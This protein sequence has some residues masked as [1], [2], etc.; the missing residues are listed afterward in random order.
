MA[1]KESKFDINTEL[2]SKTVNQFAN[3]IR[4]ERNT[5]NSFLSIYA[6]KSIIDKL[7]NINNQIIYGRRGTGKSH[8]ML[9]LQETLL[10]ENMKKT[11]K[12]LPV[13]YQTSTWI[14]GRMAASGNTYCPYPLAII[15]KASS[16]RDTSQRI[17]FMIENRYMRK[18][19]LFLLA[20]QVLIYGCAVYH[21]QSTDIPLINHK[22]ELRIDA[23]A[24]IVPS[25][26]STIS[27]GL[28]NKIAVQAF[29]SA[30]VEERY[31]FQFSP[32]FY[33]TLQNKKVIELYGG[34]GFGHANTVK[35]P[36]A[37]MP[38]ATKQSLYGNYQLYFAQFNWGKNT[39]ES[40]RLDWAIGLK[41][42]FFHSDLT[43][44]NYYRIYPE[45][46]PFSTN[47]ENSILI[48]PILA[49][50]IGNE[51]VKFTYKFS[52]TKIF[53]LN[54]T[55]NTIPIPL[56]NIGLGVNFKLK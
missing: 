15:S 48:E 1:K 43:D 37:N 22:G 42:G 35:N 8:L 32:G 47:K 6:D 9:A 53:K 54:N 21:P 56:I 36:F 29:G 39:N 7:S 31:Y 38:E 19:F 50:R 45:S 14:V 10:D 27:Y 4:A 24:S 3:V 30:G 2:V 49:F 20:T 25:A 44:E 16:I 46:E 26:F 51:K 55:G 17:K 13:E 5:P 12:D 11:S 52:F 41:T 23:G 40:K 34:Y 28:S 33:K 18:L